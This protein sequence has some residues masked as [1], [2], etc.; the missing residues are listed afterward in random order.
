MSR[1]PLGVI[2]GGLAGLGAALTAASVGREVIVW[3]SGDVGRDKV[4]G[5][6]LSPEAEEDLEALGCGDV[7]ASL[8]SAKLR[9][10]ALIG[11]SRG[12]RI[13][14]KLP[15]RAAFGVTR[16]ALEGALAQ[17]AREAG[18][19]LRERAP[20]RAID[21]AA[22]GAVEVRAGDA[23]DRAS[24]LVLAFG[25][26]S[27]LDE[28]LELP[29]AR[30]GPRSG[31]L[32]LK[33]YFPASP[34]EAD[35]ELYLVPGGYVGINPVEDGRI[36]VCALLEARGAETRA[37]WAS[38]LVRA[39]GHSALRRRLEALG[40]PPGK[41]RGLARF[42][43]GAQAV[44]RTSGGAPLLFAGDAAR[45]IPSFTGDGMAVALRSGR[46]A[47]LASLTSDPARVYARAFS[48]AFS[49]RFAASRALHAAFLRPGVFEALAP[50]FARAPR[51]VE[52]LY[53]A[54]RT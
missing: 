6:F 5:E 32:A 50:L 29:R 25:K 37:A 51:L 28:P 33:A 8:G 44:S 13:D 9:T 34:L 38:L 20:V 4:C 42:G 52:F 1:A 12:A 10:V 27:T 31:F 45:L 47:A 16:R 17:R 23:V 15:G 40:V 54:T 49:A 39:E 53:R 2:G 48:S 43:F 11:A 19:D 35:V 30:M 14:L 41:A 3:E 21:R 18:V 7:L 46:L 22:G 36:G 24:G 26:R